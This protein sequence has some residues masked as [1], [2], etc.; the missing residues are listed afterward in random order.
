MYCPNCGKSIKE[1][2]NFCRYCGVN[3]RE[4]EKEEI[5]IKSYSDNEIIKD[6]VSQVKKVDIPQDN[7][8]EL[9]LFDVKKHWMSLFWSVFFTPIFFSYFWNIFLN[10]HSVLSWIVV[11]GLLVPVIYPILRYTSDKIII[12]T[13]YVHIKLGVLNPEEID[14]PLSKINILEVS[15]SSMGRLLNYGSVSFNSNSERFDYGYIQAPE[16]LQYIIDDPARFV[17]EALE[18]NDF[19]EEDV[20]AEV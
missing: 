14:I 8:D 18:D 1:Y 19:E 17:K 9:V 7:G 15:Q 5:Q 13:R 4:E 12:T 11:L 6:E 16:E 10:T 20:K 2:D 3:L